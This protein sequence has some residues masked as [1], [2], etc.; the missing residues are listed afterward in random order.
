MRRKKGTPRNGESSNDPR[1]KFEDETHG[2][3][4]FRGSGAG[5][6]GI[7]GAGVIFSAG[8]CRGRPE[9]GVLA[10]RVVGQYGHGIR[11]LVGL[12]RANCFRWA[13]LLHLARSL[14]SEVGEGRRSRSQYLCRTCRQTLQLRPLKLPARFA[15]YSQLRQSHLGAFIRPFIPAFRI[16]VELLKQNHVSSPTSMHQLLTTSSYNITTTL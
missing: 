11:G 9:V 7:C 16:L 8:A 14:E 13:W 10:V 12:L 1:T 2:V 5:G 3:G 4:A 15:F 6:I